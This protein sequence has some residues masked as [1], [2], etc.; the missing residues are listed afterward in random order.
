[1]FGTSSNEPSQ[2]TGEVGREEGGSNRRLVGVEIERGMTAVMN[3]F[4]LLTHYDTY[5]M[6]ICT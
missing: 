5:V 3:Y 4:S 2:K 1:M 6:C